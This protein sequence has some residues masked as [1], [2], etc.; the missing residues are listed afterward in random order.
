MEDL[1]DDFPY[2]SAWPLEHGLRIEVASAPDLPTS[3]RTSCL[4]LGLMEMGYRG[5][6]EQ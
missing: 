3:H 2:Y 1:G 4:R 5:S 6:R